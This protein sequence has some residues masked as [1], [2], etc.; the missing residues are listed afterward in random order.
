MVL[1]TTT[2]FS[3]NENISCSDIDMTMT[4][5]EVLPAVKSTIIFQEN[6]RD[7]SDK[8]TDI[9]LDESCV[10]TVL[11]EENIIES[12]TLKD[13]AENNKTELAENKNAPEVNELFQNA[14][15]ELGRRLWSSSAEQ[16]HYTKGCL[17]SPDG[18]CIL[19][20][21]HLDGKQ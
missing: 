2:S 5:E 13:R 15:L 3:L 10:D 16:Q 6:T 9:S 21:V 20:P 14:L 7:L 11:I 19:T 17:W 12:D 8:F 1:D 4:T 18:T